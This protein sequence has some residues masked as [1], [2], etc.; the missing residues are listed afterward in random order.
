MLAVLLGIVLVIVAVVTWLGHL[1]AAH[2]VALG[3]GVLG[4]LLIVYGTA[5][6]HWVRRS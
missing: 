3:L 1:G 2:A 5:P 6:A 4:V